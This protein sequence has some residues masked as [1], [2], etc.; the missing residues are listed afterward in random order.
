VTKSR[1]YTTEFDFEKIT[2]WAV[3][4]E[5]NKYGGRPL[6]KTYWSIHRPGKR[7]PLK[8]VQK[9]GTAFFAYIDSADEAKSDG[10]GE[11]L[12]HQLFK[13][14]IA[15]LAGTKLKLGSFG[16]HEVTITHGE[17]EKGIQIDDCLYYAD[18]Y[19]HFNSASDI[20]L[21]WSGK[22]YIEVNHTHAVP[23]YKQE[24]LRQAR[25]PVIEVDVPQILEYTIADEN[26]T[27]P[28]EAAYIKRVQNMLQKGFLAG[29]VISDHSSVKYLE[30]KTARLEHALLQAEKNSSEYKL[31][32]DVA[33]QQ[34]KATSENE[35]RLE[36]SIGALTQG[37]ERDA[38]TINDL[39][40]RLEMEK[41][42]ASAHYKSLCY[43][44]ETMDS[45]QKDARLYKWSFW[46]VLALAVSL[47]TFL[48]YRWVITPNEEIAVQT[49][50][51]PNIEQAVPPTVSGKAQKVPKQYLPSR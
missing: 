18:A 37:R 25:L 32:A 40:G 39:V 19:W 14:A 41:E 21:K 48:L 49:V 23:P 15:G 45:Q 51:S 34:I 26:S 11:S 42:K 7:R 1:A 27:D 22:A 20:E 31:K 2:A 13:E 50:S 6:G 16:E 10:G 3:M 47:S 43:A 9:S 24:S 44:N 30:Q 35:T 46:G 5:R 28:L 33:F 8:H 38:R 12:T 29:R 17:T 4:Q 36:N